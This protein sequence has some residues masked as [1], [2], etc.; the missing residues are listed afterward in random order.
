[1][2]KVSLGRKVPRMVSPVV[3]M[4]SMVGG[5]PN[6]CTVAWAT[7]IDDEP[8]M[9]G[10]I[11]GKKRRTMDGVRETGVFSVNLPSSKMAVPTDFC[12]LVSGYD[13]DKSEVFTITPGPLGAPLID[14]CPLSMECRFK[15]VV[16]FE[17]TDLVV[18]EI[19]DVQVSEDCMSGGKVDIEKID[20][21]LYAMPG[22]PYLS[23]GGMV[24][25]AF[26]VGRNR[27]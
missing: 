16:E 26:K 21:L 15:Q 6:F 5:R 23:I 18:G 9:I 2:S 13:E 4:G 11:L 17:G 22:G 20:P 25:E 12:G 27:K 8:P 10:L 14:E 24:A 7:M 19:T 1:M 3:L